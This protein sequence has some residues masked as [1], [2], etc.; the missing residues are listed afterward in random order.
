MLKFNQ[1]DPMTLDLSTGILRNP[2]G[3][4]FANRESTQPIVNT[5]LKV[6]KL[7]IGI[8][9]DQFQQEIQSLREKDNATDDEINQAIDMAPEITNKEG[10]KGLAKNFFK[11]EVKTSTP[12]V[13]EGEDVLGDTLEGL[14][15]GPEERFQSV[16]ESVKNKSFKPLL[17]SFKKQFEDYASL[18]TLEQAEYMAGSFGTTGSG[19]FGK[20]KGKPIIKAEE[21]LI[22]NLRGAKGMTAQETVSKAKQL[23]LSGAPK[24]ELRADIVIGSPAAGKSKF[25][26]QILAP[27]HGSMIVDPDYVKPL[28]S[29]YSR[30]KGSAAVHERSSLVAEEQLKMAIANGDN[31]VLPRIG[32]TLSNLDR[33][34]QKLKDAGYSVHLKYVE[35]PPEE[36]MLRALAREKK[37]GRVTPKEYIAEVGS[38]PGQN[39]E[40]LKN[41]PRLTTSQKVSG[42]T[43]NFAEIE[44]ISARFDEKALNRTVVGIESGGTTQDIFRNID[45]GGTPNIAISPFPERSLIVTE[46]FGRKELIKYAQDSIDLLSRK[47][48]AIGG[49]KDKATGKVYLDTTVAIPEGKLNEASLLGRD[50][51]QIAGFHLGK[52]EELPLGGTGEASGIKSSFQERLKRTLE[53]TQ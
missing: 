44:R 12:S 30:G 50:A 16:I 23:Y 18:S 38:Q 31:I 48:F 47:N 7:D 11:S 32:K 51:N 15:S 27:K 20:V 41:D 33:D 34:I 49:W 17:E 36:S 14:F 37:T 24:K 9:E 39:Y 26:E 21:D 13:V 19:K 29:E 8:P 3:S 53:L 35:I 2:D 28:F 43:P 52:I 10:A 45:Y 46:K 6:P 25:A 5:V 4:F 42:M 1:I 22:Q 40:K